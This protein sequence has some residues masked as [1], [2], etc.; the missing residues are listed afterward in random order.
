MDG[1]RPRERTRGV[2]ELDDAPSVRAPCRP[3]SRRPESHDP[4]SLG[5]LRLQV[6]VVDREL[7]GEAGNMDDEPEIVRELEPRRHVRVVVEC[8]HDDLVALP[9]RPREG[10]REQEVERRH[11]LPERRLSGRAAEERRGLLVRMLDERGRPPAR[12]VRRADVRV[13]LAEVVRDRVDHLVRALRATRPVE[14]RETAVECGEPRTNR[15]DVERRRAHSDL[16]AVDDPAVARLRGQ[17][18]R[19]EA[20]SL[21]AARRLLERRGLGSGREID[22]ERRLDVDECVE[23][24]LIA[25]RHRAVGAAGALRVEAGPPRRVVHARERA[26]HEPGE[27]EVLGPPLDLAWKRASAERAPCVSRG[28]HRD[29]ELEDSRAGRHRAQRSGRTPPPHRGLACGRMERLRTLSE[30]EC[31]ERCYGW[32]YDEDTVKLLPRGAGPV[33]E[34][35]DFAEKLRVLLELRLDAREPEAA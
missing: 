6:V 31:Y 30:A 23:A 11:A 4:R 24:V 16:L 21:G 27:D 15:G 22:L 17:R 8:G 18:V 28:V 13:V 3:S 25:L 29:V 20:A 19:D 34:R 35:D 9:Q 12:R 32:R 7:A 2:G 10:A 33:A 5:E 26:A 14:E 1:V